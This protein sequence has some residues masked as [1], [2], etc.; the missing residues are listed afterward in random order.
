MPAKPKKTTLFAEERKGKI[1]QLIN[2][3]DKIIIPELCSLFGVSSSTIRN[4]LRDLQ[5]AGLITRT[6]GG[7]ISNSKSSFELLPL[8]KR[9]RM[10]KEKVAIGQKAADLISDG[11]TIFVGSGTTTHE[12]MLQILHKRALTVLV[13]DI[14]HAVLLDRNTDFQVII[15]G[16]AVRQKFHY[17]K[18][19]A[20]ITYFDRINID[21]SFLPF[22]SIHP[23]RGATSPDAL[24]A[25][26]TRKLAEASNE[27][28]LIGDSSKI[29]T[30]S[31][32]QL[33]PLHMVEAFITDDGI[34]EDDIRSFE[35]ANLNLIIANAGDV[36]MP[37]NK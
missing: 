16:G 21:K 24:L 30:V 23:Q 2:S 4:D 37:G 29:G 8:D 25:E 36:I 3:N 6:H 34:E 33:V 15:L 31:F 22:N 14:Y 7:A 19:M 10:Y 32:A 17:V 20:D 28:Y 11:D 12:L 35:N 13:N 18:Q 5:N 1:V 27:V 9:Q 26:Y